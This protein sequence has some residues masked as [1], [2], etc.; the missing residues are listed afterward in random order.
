M[1]RIYLVKYIRTSEARNKTLNKWEVQKKSSYE[2][3]SYFK[4]RVILSHSLA[5]LGLLPVK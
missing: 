3:C 1:V 2:V 4:I 5:R